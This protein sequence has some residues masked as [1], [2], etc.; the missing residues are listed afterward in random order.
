VF[1]IPKMGGATNHRSQALS[2]YVRLDED[3]S[4]GEHLCLQT[5]AEVSLL[6]EMFL[7]ACLR[8][9]HAM[10]D[11]HRRAYFVGGRR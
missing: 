11:V 10:G 6:A 2:V 1:R 9:A 7:N 3:P 5:L 8:R 4:S